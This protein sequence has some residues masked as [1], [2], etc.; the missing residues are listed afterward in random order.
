MIL[1][2]KLLLLA[3]CKDTI[4]Y[5]NSQVCSDIKFLPESI[6]VEFFPLILRY[7]Y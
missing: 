5:L 7:L 1:N 2:Y 4:T 6:Q 3:V